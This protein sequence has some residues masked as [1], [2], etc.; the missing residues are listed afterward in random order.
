[1]PRERPEPIRRLPGRPDLPE[2]IPQSPGRLEPRE[3]PVQI[4]RLPGRP[5][6]PEL[7]QRL[8]GLPVLQV[9]PGQTQQL[10]GRPEQP[11]LQEPLARRARLVLI[12]QLPDQPAP[13]AQLVRPE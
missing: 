4:R 8:P 3:L 5:D 1:M 7:I 13:R 12:Q 9:Q 10:P 6:L 2:Q 11:V